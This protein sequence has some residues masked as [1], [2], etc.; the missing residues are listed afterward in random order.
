MPFETFPSAVD[1]YRPL[2]RATFELSTTA[3]LP[4]PVDEVFSFFGDAHN[5]NV[6]T[7]P[8]LHFEVLTAKPIAMRAG[9]LIDYRI[10]LRGLPIKWRTRISLWEPSRRF[11]DEQLRGPYLEWI[12]T[13]TFDSVDGGTLMK[14]TVRYRVPGGALINRLFV[15]RDVA[16]IF[17]YRLEALRRQFACV[18]TA[19][20]QDVAFRRLR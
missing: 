3:W 10:R 15:E 7:P 16:R 19:R 18:A 11:I 4:Q 14:D 1:L 9:T 17:R 20:D 2:K 8:W 13:H 6:I 12:H 5:L